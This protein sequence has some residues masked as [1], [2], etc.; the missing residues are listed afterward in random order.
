MLTFVYKNINKY[1]PKFLQ[2]TVTRKRKVSK[3]IM[4]QISFLLGSKAYVHE[5]TTSIESV[6]IIKYNAPLIQ[7]K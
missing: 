5:F 6:V 3:I 2:V 7:W 4:Y 1:I